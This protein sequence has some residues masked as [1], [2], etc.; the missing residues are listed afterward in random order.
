MRSYYCRKGEKVIVSKGVVAKEYCRKGF[1]IV[2]CNGDI[3]QKSAKKTHLLV[4]WVRAE[5][6]SVT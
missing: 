5:E 4:A 1:D 6:L 3:R 2:C